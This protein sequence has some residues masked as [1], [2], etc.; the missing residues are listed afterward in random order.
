MCQATRLGQ[1]LG[2][3][4]KDNCVIWS[5]EE[6]EHEKQGIPSFLRGAILVR[7]KDD[8]PFCFSIRVETMVDT[9]GKIRRMLGLEKSDPVDPVELDGETDLNDLGITSLDHTSLDIGK[10]S[11]VMMAS[12]L[13]I[14][15]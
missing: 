9:G 10:Y 7:R 6:D 13:S 8:V 14:P 5:L 2:E 1:L 12:L 4:G 11:G 3:Y 15:A